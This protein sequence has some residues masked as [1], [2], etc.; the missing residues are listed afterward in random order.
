MSE[1]EIMIRNTISFIRRVDHVYEVES[2]L[3]GELVVQ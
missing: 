2:I 1:K 3:A